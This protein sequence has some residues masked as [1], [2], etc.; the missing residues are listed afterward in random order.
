MR[1]AKL[2]AR[3]GC[4]AAE[5]PWLDAAPDD[6]RSGAEAKQA[7]GLR[8]WRITHVAGSSARA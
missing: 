7:N 8:E 4:K 3:G 2:L 1:A 5:T 6:P